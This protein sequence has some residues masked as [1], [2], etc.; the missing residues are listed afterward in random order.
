[1]SEDA[2]M[3]TLETDD[4]KL[5]FLINRQGATIRMLPQAFLGEIEKH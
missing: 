3:L 2:G 1:M 4:G 5:A